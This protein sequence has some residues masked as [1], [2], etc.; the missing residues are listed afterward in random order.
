MSL[1]NSGAQNLPNINCLI[2]KLGIYFPYDVYYCF[3]NGKT[4]I[5]QALLHMNRKKDLLVHLTF[6]PR[7]QV[8]R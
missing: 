5:R 2:I 4:F 1:Y 6:D 8:S 3:F 7:N